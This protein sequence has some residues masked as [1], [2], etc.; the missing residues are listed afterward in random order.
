M[1]RKLTTEGFTKNKKNKAFSIKNIS[2]DVI[3]YVLCFLQYSEISKFSLTSKKHYNIVFCSKIKYVKTFQEKTD[4]YSKI[5]RDKNR[6]EYLDYVEK[7]KN[8]FKLELFEKEKL[9][10]FYSNKDL[11]DIFKSSIYYSDT[12]ELFKAFKIYKVEN[13]SENVSKFDD[14][15]SIN[16]VLYL[17]SS[18]K[19]IQFSYKK[20]KRIED[21]EN[22]KLYDIKYI[23]D[24][25]IIG[26]I[27]END[28]EFD[29]YFY[30]SVKIFNDIQTKSAIFLRFVS[31]IISLYFDVIIDTDF[32]DT[33]F[34]D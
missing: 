8:S 6:E 28:F 14:E 18:E 17:K 34:F 10:K 3:E 2:A 7:T 4:I 16:C 27:S 19:E 21:S 13:K 30:G 9:D 24:G 23:Y 25:N 32:Y 1:K 20:Y 11:F 33:D 26:G 29:E 15:T 12:I 5:I 31:L 22:D